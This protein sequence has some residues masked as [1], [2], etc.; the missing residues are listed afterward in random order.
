MSLKNLKNY[1]A[2]KIA[3]VLASGGVLFPLIAGAQLSSP[4]T[5]WGSVNDI[6]LFLQ[7]V[8]RLFFTVFLV[9]AVIMF[10]W[11]A[12]VY[13]TAGGDEEKLKE[14]RQRIIYG[15]VAIIVALLAA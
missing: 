3:S 14:A 9:L 1:R 6:I 2:L 13:I 15:V 10:I 4:P 7:D 8:G 12:F 5:L 11:A